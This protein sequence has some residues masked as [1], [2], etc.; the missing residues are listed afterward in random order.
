MIALVLSPFWCSIV[1]II[2]GALILVAGLAALVGIILLACIPAW[3]ITERREK[4]LNSLTAEEREA[5]LQKA[6]QRKQKWNKVGEYAFFTF[7]GAILL[8]LFWAF[9]SP[10]CDAVFRHTK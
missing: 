7:F 2:I 5:R 9:G 4:Y 8:V 6:R 10:I 3:I 1:S